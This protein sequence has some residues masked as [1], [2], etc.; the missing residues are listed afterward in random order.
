M[1]TGPSDEICWATR[2][3][4]SDRRQKLRAYILIESE[5]GRAGEVAKGVEGLT[6]NEAKVVAVDA[7]TGPFDVIAQLEAEDLDDIGRS[8]TEGIQKIDGVGRTTT[9]L[10]VRI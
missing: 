10:V 9:C 8:I 1:L 2:R 7:V 5:V 4:N 6:F 3:R